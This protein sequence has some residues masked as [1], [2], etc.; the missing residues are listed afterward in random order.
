M[1]LYEF[2]CKHCNIIIE[3]IVKF[4]TQ[5]DICP[6]CC[7]SINK[8][9]ISQCSFKLLGSGWFNSPIKETFEKESEK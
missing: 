3:K 7:R 9:E 4:G 2:E 6:K 8:K 1:P 5:T